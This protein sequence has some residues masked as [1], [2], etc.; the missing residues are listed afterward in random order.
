MHP[1]KRTQARFDES[2]PPITA[3]AALRRGLGS[4]GKP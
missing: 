4:A 2:A 3:S 1:L